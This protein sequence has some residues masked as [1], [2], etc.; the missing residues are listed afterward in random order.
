MPDSAATRRLHRV[1]R[2][3]RVVYWIALGLFVLSLVGWVVTWALGW[4]GLVALAALTVAA[5]VTYRVLRRQVPRGTVLEIDLESGVHEQAPVQG[6]ARFTGPP[7]LTVRSVVEALER[8]RSDPRITALYVRLAPSGMGMA[9]AQELAAAV[10]RFREAGKKTVAWCPTLGE[11]SGATSEYLLASTF[12]AIH[13]QPG[14]DLAIVGLTLRQ[15]YVRGLLDK[16]R[17][18]PRLDSREAYKTARYTFTER[19]MPEPARESLSAVVDAMLDQVCQHVARHRGLEPEHVRKLIDDA[20]LSGQ[21]ALDAGLIDR[22]AHRDEAEKEITGE[23]EPGRRLM[24]L[25]DYLARAGSPWRRGEAVAIVYGVGAVVRGSSGRRGLPP[26]TTMGSKDVV[27]ALR[28]AGESRKVKAVIFRIDSPGGSA[29]ASESIGR[30]VSRIRESGKPIIVSMSNLAGSGGYYVAAGASEILA[31]PGTITGSIGVVTGKLVTKEAWQQVGVNWQ[32]VKAG[33]NAGMWAGSEDFTE[34]GWQRLQQM[35]DSLYDLFKKRV[36]DGRGLS[37]EKVQELAQGRIW[38]G[39]QAA[40]SG[41]VDE[42][43][44]LADAVRR[45]RQ[46]AGIAE[47]KP[48]RLVDVAAKKRWLGLPLPTAAAAEARREAAL[49]ALADRLAPL[50]EAL[51]LDPASEGW[52]AMPRCLRR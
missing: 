6:L 2:I 26:R 32:A 15:P 7:P 48:V 22:L 51:E 46:L 20:P 39:S 37:A 13:L 5:S 10:E 11:G 43:G 36:A 38:T 33:D 42:T 44:G 34:T 25:H 47:K 17:V 14:S 21:A 45:A 24:G 35:L 28:Q 19:E 41:L 49:D 30:E 12:D 52:L 3:A 18:T 40:E 27:R 4:P 23:D 50:G 29:V 31:L 9:H 1:G 16:L 8:G